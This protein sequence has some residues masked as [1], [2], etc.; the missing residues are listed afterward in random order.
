M[1]KAQATA[2]NTFS[3]VV[4]TFLGSKQADNYEQIVEKLL[5]SL[6]ELGWRMSIKVHCLQ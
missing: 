6:I 4:Q 2:W 1:T 3:N 5:L